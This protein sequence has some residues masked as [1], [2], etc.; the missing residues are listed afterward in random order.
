MI[1]IGIS[2]MLYSYVMKNEEKRSWQELSTTAQDVS[3]EFETKF[4][5]EIAKLHLIKTIMISNDILTVENIDFL[6]LDKIQPNT[7]FTR[8][9]I[10]YPDNTLIS[11]GKELILNENIKFNDFKTSSEYLTDRKTDFITGEPCIYYLLPV[12]E[13]E[14]ISAMI[15]GVIDTKELSEIFKPM[16]YNGEANICIIDSKDGNYIMDSWHKELGNAYE[17]EERER[18]EGYE[19]VDFKNDIK[20]LQTGT[21]AFVSRTTGKNL[22]MYYTPINAFDLELAIFA[23]EDTLFANL[24]SL[25]KMFIVAGFVEVFLFIVYCWWNINIIKQLQ[26]SNQEI[27]KQKKQLEY[28]SYRDV[29]TSLFNRHKYTEVLTSLEKNTLSNVGVAYI[30]LN[31]LKQINDTKSHDAG[32]RYICNTAKQISEVFGENVYR[33]GGDEFVVF[34]LDIEKEQFIKKTELFQRNAN[35][36]K[37]S[38]SMGVLWKANCDSLGEMLR[39]AEK[40]MYAE[41]QKYYETHDRR[42]R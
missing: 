41:K 10:V 14:E 40:K 21:I 7:I 4:N 36:E 28:L 19:N 25:R 16:I 38:V 30:D 8:I 15:I 17:M 27:E 20:S 23:Q 26:R 2:H 6:Y 22:Y 24:V 29:L 35:K 39:D 32:D 34:M 11:N 33:I 13:Q 18:L 5:D 1:T 12:M 37:I 3:A 42:R 31:G 9:D